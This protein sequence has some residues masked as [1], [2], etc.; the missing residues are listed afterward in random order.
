MTLRNTQRLLLA[1]T[2]GA[3]YGVDSNP[4]GS[5]AIAVNDDLAITPLAGNPISRTVIRPFM[6]GLPALLSPG[7][8][9]IE[10]TVDWGGSGTAGTAPG[11]A[12]I[13]RS[14]RTNQ[15]V[16]A[17]AVTGTAQAGAAGS[18]TLAAAGTSAIDG[19][20]IGQIISIT[21]GTGSGDSGLITAYN[22][23]SKVCAVQRIGAT[24]TPGASSAYSIA[25]NVSFKPI[26][27]FGG[28]SDTSC[29]MVYNLAGVQHKILGFRGSARLDGFVIGSI[30]RLRF[31]GTGIYVPPA[32]VPQ[33]TFTV[34]YLNQ[35]D[36]F[37]VSD[38][39]TSAF[40]IFGYRGCLY[41]L[42]FDFAN[43]VEYGERVGCGKRVDIQDSMPTGTVVMDA[44]PMAT[45][46]PFA[47][48]LNDSSFGVISV[49]HGVGAGRRVSLVTPRCDLGQVGYAPP[50][51]GR[52]MFNLPFMACSTPP[53]GNEFYMVFS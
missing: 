37:D 53:G 14:C 30:P 48:A 17:S 44:V 33:S 42:D 41:S 39:S 31:T 35:A 18:I 10:F 49:L 9:G 25:P 22:G 36:P 52:A 2:E 40:S 3:S 13:L 46:D 50:Q 51:E 26:S 43:Q 45:F 20:Y 21:S 19:F 29:T 28:V 34:A 8:V 47:L 5:N 27:T 1:K 7:P 12:D 24:F 11:Y 6:G 4:D 32:D 38:D 23:T 16:A 15:T